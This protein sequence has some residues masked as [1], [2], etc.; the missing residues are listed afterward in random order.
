MLFRS[1]YIDLIFYLKNGYVALEL[2]FNKKRALILKANQY[3]L[4]NDVLFRKKYD[5]VLLRCLE[6]SEVENVLQELHDEPASGN[7]SGDTTTHK[8]LHVGYY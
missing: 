3:Q 2:D 7:Y 5:S 6:K 4:V 8:I 1:Q